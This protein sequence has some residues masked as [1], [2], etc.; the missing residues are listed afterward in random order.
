MHT[1]LQSLVTVARLERLPSLKDMARDAHIEMPYG[2]LGYPVL[3]AADIL[4][5][6]AHYVPVGKD[7]IAHVEITREIA[8]RFNALYGEVFPIP[9]G[10]VG[11][12]PTLV[13]LD[14]QA[15]MSKSLNNAIFL[16]DSAKEV[17]RKIRGMYTDPNRIHADVPGTVEG[18]PV[19]IYHDAFNPDRAE[20]ADLKARYRAGTVGD[21]EVKEKLA[22]AINALLEPMRERRAQYDQLGLIED[23]LYT[24]TL[25]VRDETQQTLY[26]MQKA[27]GF[28]GVWNRIRRKA[29]NYRKEAAETVGSD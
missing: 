25:R 20:V 18:N 16:S 3:Q 21:V 12:V 5:V 11:D 29:E 23:I 6:R 9:D 1:L 13:G 17:E 2:L 26:A 15:K 4:C 28:T 22:A 14:G 19:F 10:E 24:G 7:N 27:M 8:R